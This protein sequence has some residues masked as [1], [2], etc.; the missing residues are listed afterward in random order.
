MFRLGKL[1]APLQPQLAVWLGQMAG[2]TAF[3]KNANKM[4]VSAGITD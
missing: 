4:Y 1:D 3:S 2:V